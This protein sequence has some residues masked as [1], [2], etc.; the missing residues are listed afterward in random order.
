M[1]ERYLYLEHL[2]AVTPNGEV[3]VM[4]A[5]EHELVVK[6]LDFVP[7]LQPVLPTG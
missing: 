3:M 2:L 6:P 1:A 7:E 4:L 5:L